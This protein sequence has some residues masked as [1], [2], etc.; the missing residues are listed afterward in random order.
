MVETMP[1]LN[2]TPRVFIYIRVSTREQA[3]DGGSLPAQ[4]KECVAYLSRRHLPPLHEE[5]NMECAGVF[6][7]PGIS[8]WKISPFSRPGFLAMW[9]HVQDGDHIIC[10]SIDRAFRSVLDFCRVSEEF[11]RRNI[12]FHFVYQQF[13]TSSAV[14][15]MLMQ[16]AAS[17]AEFKSSL[18]SERVKE[19]YAIRKS[20]NTP[21][22]SRKPKKFLVPDQ[23]FVDAYKPIEKEQKPRTFGTAHGYVR[24]STDDQSCDAQISAV[25]SLVM[26]RVEQGYK[27]GFLWI[28]DGV[29]AFKVSLSDRPMGSEMLESL[30]AGDIVVCHRLDRMYRSIHD[31]SNSL[32]EFDRRGIFVSFSS[33]ISTDSEAG[34]RII[35]LL[36][37]MA[38]MESS[39]ISWRTKL[40]MKMTRA[41]KGPWLSPGLL[42]RYM[43]SIDLGDGKWTYA[44]R[45]EIITDIVEMRSLQSTHTNRQISDIFAERYSKFYGIPLIPDHGMS[46]ALFN[47]RLRQHGSREE[48][49]AFVDHCE[50]LGNPSVIPRPYTTMQVAAMTRLLSDKGMLKK[51]LDD[52]GGE[53]S[54][55]TEDSKAGSLIPV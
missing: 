3:A 55:I 2:R 44:I 46:T 53:L 23:R 38:E 6:Y 12:T 9:S 47:R 32:K 37:Y 35:P 51:Y 11:R 18:I 15:R 52:H 50:S 27:P 39:D 45:P 13:D 54:V 22:T 7:D 33:D 41:L 28:D 17:F 16:V 24:V 34:R 10:L 43:D 19:A 25:E 36:T 21:I 29:S 20:L 4:H 8:A 1:A 14:G 42:P 49:N 26:A 48:I 5:S 30:Q 40:G 31:M